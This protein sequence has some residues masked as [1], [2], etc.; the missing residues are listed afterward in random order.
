MDALQ[1][2]K[3]YWGFEQFRPNQHEII[4]HAINGQDTLA[5]LPT[6]GGKS[7]CYQ[8]PGIVRAGMCLVI[9]PLIAL[10]QD[11]VETLQKKKLR[12]L[13]ITSGMS[14]KEIDFAL[15]HAQFGHLD[16]LYVSPE[17]LQTS[18]FLER[19]KNMNLSLIAVD[20]AHCISEWG[21]DFRPSYKEIW[22][23]RE[24]KPDVPILALTAT[25]TPRVRSDISEQLHLNNFFFLEGDFNRTNLS[26]EVYSSTNKMSHI[27]EF[28]DKN[29]E[30]CGIIYC[31]TRRDTKKVASYLANEKYSVGIYHGGL[32]NEL[33][34]EQLNNWMNGYTKIMVATNAFGMGIDKPNVRFVLHYQLPN[35]LEAYYQEAGRSGRD[36]LPSRNLAWYT[37][38]DLESMQSKFEIQFPAVEQIK[39]TYAAICNFLNIA[40]GSGHMES[41]AFDIKQFCERY[42]FDSIHVFNTLKILQMNGNIIFNEKIFHGTK[43]KITISNTSLYNFQ[44]KNPKL[45]LIITFLC[46]SYPGLFSNFKE[47][48]E[49][50]VAQKLKISK[51]QVIDQLRLLEKNGVAEVIYKSDSPQIIFTH[52]RLPEELL[53]L[54]SAAYFDRKKVLAEKLESMK[55]FIQLDI[56][57]S[58]QLLK[59]FGQESTACEKCDVC[60]HKQ[61]LNFSDDELVEL[62][63]QTLKDRSKSIQEIKSELNTIDQNRIM[64]ILNFM[65]DNEQ[66]IYSDGLFKLN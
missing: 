65:V 32:S 25:A 5:L 42:K 26:Y 47:I 53:Q 61:Q 40:I 49:E 31:Q 11:Q 58:I 10:M 59:Y 22:K 44:I 62:I 9:S 7:I 56:C 15:D 54:S 13:A 57:R 30:Y 34:K 46:R 27:A 48:D 14:F 8:V 12:A 43:L 2:L 16:F 38:A 51:T 29:A 3:N 28:C 64:K 50:K 35:N 37:P 60:L 17:R 36:G 19:F 63:N 1:T 18:I 23:L 39:N 21:H 24:L 4:Q 6:G 52:E 20:E 55:N 41:Y 66:L 33:R 45:D